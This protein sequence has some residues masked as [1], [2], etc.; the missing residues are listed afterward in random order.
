MKISVKGKEQGLE[1]LIKNPAH[2]LSDGDRQAVMA[3]KVEELRVSVFSAIETL[4]VSEQQKTQIMA[5]VVINVEG[6]D[7]LKLRITNPLAAE[8]EYGTRHST[9]R[10]WL[11]IL[12]LQAS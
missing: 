6:R 2:V 7:T 1:Q 11:T 4:P 8:F 10:E 12:K 3:R 5:S 9:P